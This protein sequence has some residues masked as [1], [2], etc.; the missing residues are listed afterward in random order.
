[1][2]SR[3]TGAKPAKSRAAEKP[4]ASKQSNVITLLNRA[5]GVNIA[6]IMQATGWQPHSVRGFFRGVVR[7]KLKLNLVSE[8]TSDQRT[9]RIV[10]KNGVKRTSKPAGRKAA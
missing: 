1:M 9:Y 6:T 2:T 7:K 5:K 4:T 10:A 3:N 8:K